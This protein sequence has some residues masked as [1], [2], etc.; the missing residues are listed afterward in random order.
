VAQGFDVSHDTA[1]RRGFTE[2]LTVR[3]L[4]FLT[5]NEKTYPM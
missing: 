5:K 1:V 2:N 3:A 4:G